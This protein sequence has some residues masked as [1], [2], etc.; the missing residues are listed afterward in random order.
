MYKVVPFRQQHLA[1]LESVGS[2]E[3]IQGWKL[4]KEEC[5][6]LE[7]MDSWTG[8]W[9]GE[10]IVCAGLIRHWPGRSQAWAFMSKNA[11]R[12]MMWI[13][14]RVAE[15]LAKVQGRIEMTVRMDFVPGQRWA[16]MLGFEV[17]SPCMAHY[18]PEGESHIGY[19][20]VN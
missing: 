4:T 2:A 13:T 10:P 20:R 15:H 11:G 14:K 18:G 6:L 5:D 3:T 16:K 12:H 9:D 1:W 8:V 19:A 17:E 7:R